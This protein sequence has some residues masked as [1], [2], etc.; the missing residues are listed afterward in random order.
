MKR[1]LTVTILAL[2]LLLLMVPTAVSAASGIEVTSRTGDGEWIEDAWQVEIFPGE[3]KSTTLTLYSS[4]SSSLDVEVIVAP[5]SLD[6]GNLVF[7]LDKTSFAMP[8]KSYVDVVLAVKANGSATPGTY[9]TELTLKSEIPP[10]PSPTPPV[11]EPTP[12]EPE[13]PTEP[14]EPEPIE[15][16]PEEPE[17]VEPI[18]EPEEEEPEPIE[19]EE[20]E[21]IEPVEPIEPEGLEELIPIEEPSRWSLL[22]SILASL[23][24]VA[25]G[26]V[27]WQWQRRNKGKGA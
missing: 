19:P 13:E 7:E 9:T 11:P 6:N 21:P 27:I 16:E 20:E 4:S 17:I 18:E 26:M 24:L 14:E 25:L 8:R 22:D 2:S 12:E 1:I 23:A 3:V 15:P 5:D 10:A